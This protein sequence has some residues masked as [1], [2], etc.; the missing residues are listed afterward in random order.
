MVRPRSFDEDAVLEG[1]MGLFWRRGYDGATLEAL[2]RATGLNRGS[3]YNAFG[4]KRGLFLAS[5][6][7][8]VR[9]EIDPAVNAVRTA[10]NALAALAVLFPPG[11]TVDRRGCLICKAAAEIAPMDPEVA[12]IAREAY[13]PLREALSEAFAASQTQRHPEHLAAL[14]VAAYQGTKIMANAGESAEKI[15]KVAAGASAVVTN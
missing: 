15:A 14:V 11:T 13:R 6:R 2:D 10:P 4:D 8:Y 3:L 1:A 12:E 7:R 9:L 5:L